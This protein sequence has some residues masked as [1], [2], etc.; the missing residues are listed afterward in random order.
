MRI[1]HVVPTYAP[2][3]RHGGPVRAVDGLARAQ[4]RLGHEVAVFTTHRNGSEVLDVPTDRAVDREGVEV[5]YCAL[6]WP[7]RID[8]APRLARLLAE[9][10]GTFEIVHLHSVFLWPTWAAAGAAR[11]AEVPYLIS[12]RGILAPELIER[13]GRW[14]KR[15]WLTLVERRNLEAAAAVH[16]TSTRER[17]DVE[18]LGLRIRSIVE[19]PNG[20]DVPAEPARAGAEGSSLSLLVLGR[21]SWKKGIDRAIDVLSEMPAARLLVAGPDEEGLSAELR[22]RAAASGVAE[23]IEWIGEV[24]D[25]GR[26]RLFERTDVLLLPSRSENFGNVVTEA[27]AAGLPVVVTPEVGAA[28]LVR[29]AGAGL[30][31]EGERRALAAA[32]SELAADPGR[33]SAMGE[34]GRRYA[35][36]RLEWNAVAAGMVDAYRQLRAERSAA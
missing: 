8:R 2:A 4:A 13:R 3:W 12:P 23:R 17:R 14:R 16:V 7:R 20:V 36:D 6:A 24:D 11:R 31:V 30:V 22:A 29:E 15:L 34:A 33:R 26:D 18:A 10:V 5:H 25:A 21:V 35:L 9:R 1:L 27:M 28:E 19:L 32:C